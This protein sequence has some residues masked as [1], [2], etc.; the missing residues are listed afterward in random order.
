M[1]CPLL[2][3]KKLSSLKMGDLIRFTEDSDQEYCHHHP[4]V[5]RGGDTVFQIYSIMRLN[6]YF[7]VSVSGLM[8]RFVYLD[9]ETDYE[10]ISV[11]T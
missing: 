5:Q 1:N 8:I 2:R 6:V 11:R 3:K 9:C 7:M 10:L 4:K